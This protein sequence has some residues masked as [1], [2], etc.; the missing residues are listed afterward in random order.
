MST[1]S[2]ST[3]SLPSSPAATVAPAVRSSHRSRSVS[4][5]APPPPPPPQD[6]TSIAGWLEIVIGGGERIADAFANKG[7]AT[8]NDVAYDAESFLTAA[9]V[10]ELLESA[11]AN[12]LHVRRITAA[13][14]AL[15]SSPALH[16]GEF[17]RCLSPRFEA[18]Q[19]PSL[20]QWLEGVKVGY[21]RFAAAFVAAGYEDEQDLVADRPTANDL[22]R[23]LADVSGAR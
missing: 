4:K 10:K 6:T 21:S 3:R 16:D 1:A 2:R 5:L 18:A 20:T 23:I 7:Y 13:V 19:F 14:K 15:A 8:T 11:G 12:P 17:E 9:V 22:K